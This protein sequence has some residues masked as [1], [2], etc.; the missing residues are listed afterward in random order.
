VKTFW[1]IIQR[2]LMLDYLEALG[3]SGA[4]RMA[5]Y[6]SWDI[7]SQFAENGHVRGS[8]WSSQA[9]N[10]FRMLARRLEMYWCQ[11]GYHKALNMRNR[12]ILAFWLVAGEIAARQKTTNVQIVQ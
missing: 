12:V 8:G 9:L 5:P 1:Q 4:F 2:M 6:L 11:S 10:M 3:S 7:V